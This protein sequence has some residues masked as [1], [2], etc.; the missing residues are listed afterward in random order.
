[1]KYLFRKN[2]GN[3]HCKVTMPDAL[4]V[5]LMEISY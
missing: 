1:M 3:T 4:N 5:I 2:I